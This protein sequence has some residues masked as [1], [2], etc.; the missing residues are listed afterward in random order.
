MAKRVDRNQPE[1]VKLWRELGYEVRV[2]SDLGGGFPD[3]VLGRWG[4]TIPCEIKSSARPSKDLTPLERAFFQTW[5]GL[6]ILV[7]SPESVMQWHALLN[8]A[9]MN[10][11]DTLATLREYRNNVLMQVQK[12]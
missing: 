6:A 2:T 4:L 1:I 9:V 5:P 7:H 12:G 11:G 3:V 10:S 8:D